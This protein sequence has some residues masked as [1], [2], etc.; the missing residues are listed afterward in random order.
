MENLE[1]Y[2]SFVIT[3]LAL[4]VMARIEDEA[5]VW[6]FAGVKLLGNVILRE[7]FS[8]RMVIPRELTS[9]FKVL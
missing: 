7:F 2:K 8:L 3:S 1:Y 5:R 4:I 6:C 9:C